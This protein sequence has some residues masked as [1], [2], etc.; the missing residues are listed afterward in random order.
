MIDRLHSLARKLIR[1]RFLFISLAALSIVV[2]LASLLSV[3]G[4][5]ADVHLVPAILVFCWSA[6]LLSFAGLLSNVP[7][8]PDKTVRWRQRLAIRLQRFTLG[9]LGLLVVALS[10]AVLVLSWQ[11]LRT[12]LT[13]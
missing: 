6:T 2:L 13:A 9:M 7:S 8:K 12:W 4:L 5:S 11:L 3:A 1:G 10:I